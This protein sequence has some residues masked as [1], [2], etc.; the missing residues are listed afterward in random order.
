M[1]F[2]VE[3]SIPVLTVFLQGLLSF[4]SPCVLPLVPLYISYLAGGAKRVDEQ[5]R[6][7]YPRKK[8]MLNTLF[9]VIG[10]SFTFFLLGMGVT[11]LGRFFSDNRIWFARISGIVMIFFGLYQLG[12]FGRS[13]KLDRE[14][15]LPFQLDRWSMNPVTALI[16]GFT[17]SFAWTPC[18]G[19]TLGSVLLMA[20][21]SGS[22]QTGML[23]IG[24]YTL[25]F[26]IPFLAVGLFTGAVL[27]FFRK[28]QRVVQYTVK[29]GGILLVFMGIMTLTGMMNGI[30]SYLSSQGN[31]AQT[32]TEQPA[33]EKEDSSK[34]KKDNHSVSDSETSDSDTSDTAT[35]APDFTLV[36]QNGETHKLSDYKGKTVFLNFWATWCP[37][38]RQE[39]PDIQALYE[40]YGENKEDLIVL[41]VANP[42]TDDHPNNQDETQEK[43]AGFLSENGYTYPVAMDTTG[44]VFSAYGISSFPTTFMIDK[45]GN[46]YGYVSGAITADIMESI[47]TQTMEG[48]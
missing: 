48:E 36:D 41:G 16:L 19:P 39:M 24:V 26:V 40:T 3:T 8:V 22:S 1:G 5:G 17:F 37:P 38:C 33:A 43:V 13:K 46:V 25:G 31:S 47:V 21:S 32:Q 27:G 20:S 42:K 30:T 11:S 29:V 12:L 28:Y 6:I 2:S 9:F 15:R 7:F 23:L 18:V 4:F 35:P 45:E 14:H 34:D 10:I 44:D